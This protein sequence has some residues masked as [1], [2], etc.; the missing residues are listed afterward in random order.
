MYK[1]YMCIICEPDFEVSVLRYAA[2]MRQSL[3]S[4]LNKETRFPPRKF[5]NPQKTQIEAAI[6]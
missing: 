1:W 6:V 2:S 5:P 4:A 3:H